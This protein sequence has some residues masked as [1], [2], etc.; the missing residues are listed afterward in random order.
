[1]KPQHDRLRIDLLNPGRFM[2]RIRIARPE[3]A[4]I[5]DFL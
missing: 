2:Q 3:V 4:A 1:L 5:S